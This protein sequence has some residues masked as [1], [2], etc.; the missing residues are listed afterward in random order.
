MKTLKK[1]GMLFLALFAVSF[2]SAQNDR[3][4]SFEQLP[5]KAQSFIKQHFSSSDVVSVLEDNE[6]LKKKEYTVY[7][8]NGTEIEFYSNGDW[9]EVKSRTEKLPEAIIPNRIAQ[10]V[11]KNFPNVFIKELKKRRQGYEIELSNGLDLIFNKAG[12]FVRVDD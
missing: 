2:A 4:I 12:K 5:A 3:V 6:Y 7:L 8:N 10:H 1:V 11:K 9:E